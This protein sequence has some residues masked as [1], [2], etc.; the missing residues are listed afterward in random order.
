MALLIL[1]KLGFGLK[2]RLEYNR[3]NGMAWDGPSLALE[4]E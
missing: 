1:P 4:F 3:K 2:D